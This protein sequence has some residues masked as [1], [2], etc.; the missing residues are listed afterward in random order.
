[1]D[2]VELI[3]PSETRLDILNTASYHLAENYSGPWPCGFMLSTW[4]SLVNGGW[5]EEEK[6]QK[7]HCRAFSSFSSSCSLSLDRDIVSSCRSGADA[8]Q[9]GLMTLFPVSNPSQCLRNCGVPG[10]SPGV[11]THRRSLVP[12]ELWISTHRILHCTRLGH[13]LYDCVD[14]RKSSQ[15]DRNVVDEGNIN[16][17]TSVLWSH[18][19]PRTRY[20]YYD[21]SWIRSGSQL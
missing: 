5:E 20:Q 8:M 18:A 4:T 16:L 12:G 7:R 13:T 17:T 9:F 15:R 19:N 3:V 10:V 6:T 2:K 21:F 14:Q 1:M 11:G